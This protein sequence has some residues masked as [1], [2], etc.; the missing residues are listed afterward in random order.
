MLFSGHDWKLFQ[1]QAHGLNPPTPPPN[2]HSPCSPIISTTSPGSPP[3]RLRLQEGKR[4]LSQ[5]PRPLSV[6]HWPLP[7]WFNSP[8]NF[9]KWVGLSFLYRPVRKV[10]EGQVTWAGS[11][12]LEVVAGNWPGACGT[13]QL[14]TAGFPASAPPA[15]S[16][17]L[18][19]DLVVQGRRRGELPQGARKGINSLV[20]FLLRKHKTPAHLLP[21]GLLEARPVYL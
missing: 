8:E 9:V 4:D 7:V 10:Q 6:R 1:L 15:P 14:P 20:S 21:S 18:G 12:S 17:S 5:A 2:M 13:S 16:R 19:V 11:H 3:Q